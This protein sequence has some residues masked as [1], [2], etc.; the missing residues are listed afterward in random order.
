MSVERFNELARALG[1]QPVAEDRPIVCVQGLGFVGAAMSAAVA[2]AR[3]E[4]GK[5]AFN[6]IGVDLANE[7]GEAKVDA[8]NGGR[9]PAATSDTKLVDAV[10]QGH[11]TGNLLATTDAEVFSAAD[12][13]VVDIHLDIPYLD[14]EPRL[15]MGPFSA[16]LR[17]VAQ[18]A[19]PGALVVVETTV[20]PG[21]CEKVVVPVV[22]E[23][24][25][26]RGLDGDALLIAHSYERVM[27]GDEYLDSI[28][29]Y[30]RVFAGHT[31]AAGDAC[32]TFLSQVINV[33]DY[34]LTRLSSTTASET[35]KVMENTYR[36]VNIAFIQEW[37]R[38]AETVGIDLFEV[39][40][41]IRKRPT[42]QNIRQPGL[43]V[44]GYC[45]TK[46]PTFAPAA[47]SQ[48][49]GFDPLEFP[50]SAMAV[51]TNHDMPRHSVHRLRELLGED[52]HGKRALMLGVS[53][54]EDVGDTRY[55]PSEILYRAL[56]DAGMEVTAH[57]P[58]VDEWE[59]VRLQVGGAIP[60]ATGYDAILFCV[61]HKAYRTLDISS[62][63]DGG[64]PVLLDTN[65]VLD[66]ARRDA[67]RQAGVR[68]E[69]IG[70]GEGL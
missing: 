41:A 12:I 8:I 35:A 57:D 4:G 67:L 55:S 1:R 68:V 31:R 44:G 22:T 36:A 23:E 33:A 56:S 49:F 69:S 17:S 13:I 6:V 40:N 59:E 9:F 48:L 27:P 26:K 61:A 64:N 65:N 45:L 14:D 66:G 43:G 19:R 2:M 46:D 60:V 15:E 32:E 34:P 28:I 18:R 39:V 62:W 5:P 47:V 54:R 21:T 29:N 20:P 58:Y 7:F 37:T 42:H 51:R 53:Y 63:L 16:A 10:R 50:F 30:W 24:L 11:E 25:A 70:R 38:Y 3:D 52:L